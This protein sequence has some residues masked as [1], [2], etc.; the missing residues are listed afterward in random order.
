M[1]NMNR[2]EFLT[3]ATMGASSLVMPTFIKKGP[4]LKGS[5]VVRLDTDH[6]ELICNDPR[7]VRILQLT[8]THFGSPKP[9]RSITDKFSKK[10]IKSLVDQQKPD[11]VFHTGD[12]INN[13]NEGAEHSAIEFMN[14]LGTPWSL[15]FGNHDHQRA[16]GA[17]S[18]D[19]YQNRM[20]NHAAGYRKNSDGTHEHCFRIDFKSKSDKPGFTLIGFNCGSPSTSMEV[21]PTQI[22]WFKQQLE[23]DARLGQ[24]QPIIVMQHI[25]TIEYKTLFD[26]GAAVGRQGETVCF[27]QDNGGVFNEYVL[28]RRVKAIFCGHDH[29]NDY[30]GEHRGIKLVYGRV[31]GW[32]GYGDW[33]RG[34]RTIDLDLLDRTYKTKVVLPEGAMDMNP[35]WRK[36]LSEDLA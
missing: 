11:L 34:G 24:N 2:R 27:E 20:E 1:F 29:V 3:A 18:L 28:S 23:A 14:D 36:T 19:E 16:K 26:K 7:K 22:E 35:E 21:T 5:K 12:F 9:E 33:Q 25:P 31:S 8:D 15:V 6:F 4:I 30:I 17:I 13:D 10:L 32:S